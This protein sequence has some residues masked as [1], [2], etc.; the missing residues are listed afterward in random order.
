MISY[1]AIETCSLA[2][3]A[4]YSS[5]HAIIK[6]YAIGHVSFLYT[7]LAVQSNSYHGVPILF[8]G[9]TSDTDVTLLLAPSD[10]A[11]PMLS[12]SDAAA[13][14]FADMLSSLVV[15]PFAVLVS[16]LIACSI[17]SIR[18]A[19][20]TDDIAPRSLRRALNRRKC[21]RLLLYMLG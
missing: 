17:L 13:V 15:L 21:L 8:L 11:E 9:D 5:T 19:N 16:A 18:R 12:A 2:C 4:R 7:K 20:S 3:I 10:D 1:A 6:H 14:V